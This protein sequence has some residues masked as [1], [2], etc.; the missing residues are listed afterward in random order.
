[1]EQCVDRINEEI[2]W[3]QPDGS[4]DLSSEATPKATPTTAKV[5]NRQT[6]NSK[7]SGQLKVSAITNDDL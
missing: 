4:A 1:M 6:S 2:L 7:S 5:V 3:K